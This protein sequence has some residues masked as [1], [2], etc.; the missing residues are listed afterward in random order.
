MDKLDMIISRLD[1]LEGKIDSMAANG[2]AKAGFHVDHEARLRLVENTITKASG[3][4]FALTG[5]AGIAGTVGGWISSHWKG[6]P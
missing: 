1:T 2:C 5:L 3:A 6:N 4:A